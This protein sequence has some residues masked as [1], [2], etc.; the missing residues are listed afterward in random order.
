MNNSAQNRDHRVLKLSIGPAPPHPTTSTH[1][2]EGSIEGCMLVVHTIA[3][4][5]SSIV[6]FRVQIPFWFLFLALVGSMV[7][8]VFTLR[9][10]YPFVARHNDNHP[11][12][13]VSCKVSGY[14]G[15]SGFNNINILYNT[16]LSFAYT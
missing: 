11:R 7:H 10:C 12:A 3:H 2:R 1:P 13:R 8:L 15:I 14:L 4:N 6:Q 9:K 5:F 16:L